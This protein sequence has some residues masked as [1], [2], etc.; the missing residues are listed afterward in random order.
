MPQP[1]A[2]MPAPVF[3]PSICN[4]RGLPK[5]DG[6]PCSAHPWLHD[7]CSLRLPVLGGEVAYRSQ[8]SG[9]TL[10]PQGPGGGGG[11]SWLNRASREF[12]HCPASDPCVLTS[13]APLCSLVPFTVVGGLPGSHLAVRFFSAKVPDL[14]PDRDLRPWTSNLPPVQPTQPVPAQH[15]TEQHISRG[16]QVVPLVCGLQKG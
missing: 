10:D 11:L 7:P 14:S 4:N 13:S 15:M 12:Q 1:C 9:T 5:K 6:P 8:P 3:F 16:G 2:P